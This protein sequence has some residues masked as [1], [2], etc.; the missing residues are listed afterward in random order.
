MF[1]K[2]I[3]SGLFAAA[4]VA[5][6]IAAKAVTIETVPVGNPGNAA[7]WSGES[8]GGYGPDR[9]CGA[10]NYNYQMGKYEVTAGQYTE[11]LNAKAK[12]DPY[13]LYSIEM[14]FSASGCRIQRSGSS[15][16][17]TY[18]VPS[19]WANRPVNSVSFWSAARF[20][21]WLHN[22]QHDGDTETGAYTLEGYC[23][24]HGATI[25]RNPGAKW[26]L[27]T[28]DEW[29]KAAYFAPHKPG[30]AGYW[31]YPMMSDQPTVPSNDL[32]TPDG[33]NNANFR[34][35]GYT[36]GPPYY[37]T[38]VGEFENSASAYETFDQGGNVWEWL[39]QVV[40]ED[41]EYSYRGVRGGCFASTLDQLAS[42]YRAY[43]SPNIGGSSLGFR[44]ANVPEP[45][46][47]VLLL[48]ATL[49]LLGHAWRRRTRTA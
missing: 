16:D 3:V 10:V 44:V 9:L 45:G 6:A 5:S 7:E 21:N 40:Y 43:V 30:G 23:G 27:P 29:Y 49:S 26:C 46:S 4:I 41:A 11:F 36:L 35:D 33:G 39:D 24:G 8:Y 20:C 18:T 37:I 25:A 2:T 32:T 34:P 48:V 1:V 15:G 47:M 42:S 19:D 22:G 38:L 17:F 12:S 13:G 28:E 14:I 31:D